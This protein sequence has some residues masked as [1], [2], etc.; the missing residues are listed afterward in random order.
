M[1]LRND[2]LFDKLHEQVGRI[3]GERL[4]TLAVFGSYSS[5]RAN[6]DSDMDILVVAGSFPQGRIARVEEWLPVEAGW[7]GPFLSPVFY[8]PSEIENGSPLFLNMT[9]GEVVLLADKDSFFSNYLKQLKVKL[10]K[11]GSR[12][13]G[14]GKSSYWI[15]G[16]ASGREVEI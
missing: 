14:S 2:S 5:G 4:I 7:S 6:E 12:R 9:L 11:M 15:M 8:T 13:I 10:A 3:Y 1:V 16:P